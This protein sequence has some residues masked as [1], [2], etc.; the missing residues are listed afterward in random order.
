MEPDPGPP[1]PYAEAIKDD[2]L[3][4]AVLILAGQSI[5]AEPEPET[6]PT[7]LY[8]LSQSVTR[9]PQRSSS[10]V[11]E[12]VDASK[13][14]GT[15]GASASARTQHLFYIVHPANAR[16]RKDVPAY[17]LTTVARETGLGNIR[18]EPGKSQIPLQR[19]DF[20]AMLS[21]SRTMGDKPLFDGEGERVL[22]H[23]RPSSKWV[24]GYRWLDSAGREVAVE[25]EDKKEEGR[26]R[27][28]VGAR[29]Q[30]AK[31][32]ALVALWVLRV[33]HE[34]AESPEARRRGEYCCS[35]CC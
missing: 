27:L 19:A 3:D 28:V 9:I 32:D 25:E 26:H 4:P 6:E 35:Y 11:F 15:A 22:F 30:R 10:V 31:R 33:W 13:A 14:K 24:R 2:I 5:H 16:Y 21:A 7:P 34:T 18:L 17:Y 20:A 29:M 12:R 8:Q 1:P 23:T